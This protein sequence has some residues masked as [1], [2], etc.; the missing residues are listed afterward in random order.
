METLILDG[1]IEGVGLGDSREGL[2]RKWSDIEF[3]EIIFGETEVIRTKHA[4]AHVRFGKVVY[5]E[6]LVWDDE[7]LGYLFGGSIS[8][9]TTIL[10]FLQHLD[11]QNISWF[12]FQ[13]LCVDTQVAVRIHPRKA[14]A[15]FDLASRRFG[16][17]Y[18][19]DE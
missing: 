15:I 8:S 10:S 2:F 9:K 17:L 11:E 1:S 19:S 13:P 12:V 7:Y 4:E 16:K 3:S 14:I 5:L 6:L 18:L